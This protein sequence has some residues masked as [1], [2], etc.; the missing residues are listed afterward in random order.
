MG[1]IGKRDPENLTQVAERN[2]LGKGRCMHRPLGFLA[3]DCS[4]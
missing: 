2:M 1:S 4:Y 3:G